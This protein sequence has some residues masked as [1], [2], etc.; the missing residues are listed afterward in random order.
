[1]GSACCQKTDF[2]DR[3]AP[4][5][6]HSRDI[7]NAGMYEPDAKEYFKVLSQENARNWKKH[8]VEL[9]PYVAE[10]K[11]FRPFEVIEGDPEIQTTCF[12]LI[13]EPKFNA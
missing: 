11:E 10:S 1:M 13:A 3:Q 4:V 8:S 12:F 2:R 5:N 7:S 6:R 9:Q